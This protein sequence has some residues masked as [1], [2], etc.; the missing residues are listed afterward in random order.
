MTSPAEQWA[1][2]VVATIPT[3][4]PLP[5]RAALLLGWADDIRLGLAD[6]PPDVTDQA[7]AGMLITA[8]TQYANQWRLQQQRNSSN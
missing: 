7:A 5:D 3:R 4:A 6:L 8:A 2:Q 1:T